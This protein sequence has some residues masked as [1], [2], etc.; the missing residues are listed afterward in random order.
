MR[1][2]P[3]E[4]ANDTPNY[5]ID[6]L[7][8]LRAELPAERRAVL[9]DGR[10]LV[11]R[12]APLASR[13]GDSLCRA[14]DC[15]F[16]AR[17]EPGRSGRCVCR[18]GS[19]IDAES[20]QPD[21]GRGGP[22]LHAAECGRRIRALLPAAGSACGHQRVGDSPPGPGRSWAPGP[23]GTSFCPTPSRH[24]SRRTGSIASTNQPA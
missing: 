13:R 11:P 10:R 19:P 9:P 5:T 2:R 20:A 8:A 14:A 1:P 17:P 22:L 16:A 6:T 15:R 18:T 4:H 21:P 24:T 23:P 12:A 3:L 7:L